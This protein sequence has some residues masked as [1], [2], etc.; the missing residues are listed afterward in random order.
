MKCKTVFCVS[1]VLL[2]ASLATA[3]IPC[4]PTIRPKATLFVNWPQLQYDS[5]HSGCN[6]YETILNPNTVENLTVKWQLAGPSSFLSPVIADGAVYSTS[7][8][9]FHI[10]SSTVA[11]EN[12]NTG[13]EIWAY[14]TQNYYFSSPVV[15]NGIV[16]AGSTDNNLY[17]LNAKTGNLV[18]KYAT[19]DQVGSPPAVANGMVYF[20]AD[21]TY[22]L[23]ASTGALIWTFPD[24]SLFS[25]AVANG[26]VYVG[27]GGLYA[28]NATT[29]DLL[30]EYQTLADVRTAPAVA[31]GRVYVSTYDNNLDAVNANT[32]ALLWTYPVATSV[33]PA[34]GKDKVYVVADG[35]NVYALNAA[36]GTLVWSY[37][38]TNDDQVSSP[39]VANGVVYVSSNLHYA[40][41]LIC[42]DAETGAELTVISTGVS[43]SSSTVAN[44]VVYLGTAP[45]PPLQISGELFALSLNGR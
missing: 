11:A 24:G 34:V 19:G 14:T 33:A 38:N 22:A 25:P 5:G 31:N 26:V 37:N 15:A 18:W 17:A 45:Y 36:T 41:F 35:G 42:L 1:L 8:T 6:P 4:G 7:S 9:D 3:Q 32:G 29:G 20:G 27:S 16:Y 10:S 40:G 2:I 30:W 12:A 21:Q 13:G 39:V 44:G 28:L 43:G 23:N